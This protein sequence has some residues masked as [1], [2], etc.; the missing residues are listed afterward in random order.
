MSSP[1]NRTLPDRTFVSPRIVFIVVDLPLAL[2]PSRETISPSPTVRRVAAQRVE[3][4]VVDVDVVEFEQVG[5]DSASP[6]EPA[7]AAQVGLDHGGIAA[8][9]LRRPLRDDPAAVHHDDAVGDRH[10]EVELVLDQQDRLPAGLQL[11]QLLEHLRGLGLVHAGGRLVEHEQLRC[12]GERP[13]DLGAAPVRVAERVGG[14]VAPRARAAPG[15]GRSPSR[16]RCRSASARAASRGCRRSRRTAPRA[17][18][19]TAARGGG[20]AAERPASRVSVEWMP[21]SMLSATERVAKTR[22]FWKVRA[23]PSSAIRAVS[24]WSMRAPS[25]MIVPPCERIV[26]V[27]RFSVVVLPEPFGPMIDTT[28]CGAT[29]N[30]IPSTAFSPSNRRSSD[31]TASSAPL[32]RSAPGSR[33]AGTGRRGSGRG[34]RR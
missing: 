3:R 4:A 32:M 8:D 16:R 31:S 19:S 33:P 30:E 10:H 11:E 5:H 15:T 28:S 1:A 25:S 20:T 18:G 22:P 7:A 12:E 21:T 17:S 6:A 34:R 13:G 29:V 9:R 2:P 23:T 24:A 14:V 27:T 26:P